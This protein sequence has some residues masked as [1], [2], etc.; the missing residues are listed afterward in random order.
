MHRRDLKALLRYLAA[1]SPLYPLTT[2]REQAVRAGH[3]PA[4]ADW[5]IA[6]FQG[7]APLPPPPVWAPALLVALADCALAGLSVQ[8]FTRFGMGRL[9]CS[10]IVLVPAIFLVELL[11][12]LIL[13]ASGKEAWGRALLLG[14]LV[15]AAMGLLV[16]LALLI[17]WATKATGA[18]GA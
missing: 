8:L 17:H 7:R 13:L 3:P 12:G 16:L 11:A 5:A 10:S 9:A 15:F 14:F 18:A 6:V 2:L 1:N 4:D